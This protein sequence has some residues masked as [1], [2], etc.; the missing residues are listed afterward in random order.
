MTHKEGQFVWEIKTESQKSFIFTYF[1]ANEDPKIAIRE[2]KCTDHIAVDCYNFCHE[3]C[4]KIL[5]KPIQTD[6]AMDVNWCLVGMTIKQ[7]CFLQ[8]VE[9]Q[10]SDTLLQFPSTP[11]IKL[12]TTMCS[13]HGK[14]MI[15]CR[16]WVSNTWQ[17]SMAFVGN[18][19]G[20]HANNTKYA[21]P[22]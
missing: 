2:H 7:V 3:V 15:K 16:M 19:I 20:Y 10:T 17:T 9:D 14:L 18:E 1:W 13:N 22:C 12:G 11:R 6:N 4:S 8:P 21:G 5:Q